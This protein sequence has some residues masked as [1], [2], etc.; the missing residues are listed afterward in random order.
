MYQN[1]KNINIEAYKPGKSVIKNINYIKLS[2]NE[3]SLGISSKVLKIFK[4]KNLVTNRYPDS[5][6]KVLRQQFQNTIIA[7]LIK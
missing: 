5:K 4:N 7:I 1:L 2:A 3:F 6:S